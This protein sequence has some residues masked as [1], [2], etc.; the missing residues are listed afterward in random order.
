MGERTQLCWD[1]SSLRE[2]GAPFLSIVACG[3]GLGVSSRERGAAQ[4]GSTTLVI[5][6]QMKSSKFVQ[7]V[8]IDGPFKQEQKNKREAFLN[9][10][11]I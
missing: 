4:E 6:A 2:F 5:R 10:K 3:A 7:Q 8:H 9:Q 1:S 11:L